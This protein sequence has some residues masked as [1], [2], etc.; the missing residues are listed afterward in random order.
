MPFLHGIALNLGFTNWFLADP[1]LKQY[2]A[3]M[4]WSMVSIR[5]FF[6]FQDISNQIFLLI[7][8]LI[9][10]SFEECIHENFRPNSLDCTDL[11][12]C[13]VRRDAEL[14]RL[15]YKHFFWV[16]PIS[17]SSFLLPRHKNIF[18]SYFQWCLYI[19]ILRNPA[20]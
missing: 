13:G 18:F 17:P 6:S 9:K 8:L 2:L 19:R 14:C 12:Q 16:K 15:C 5:H 3:K 11:N 7:K 10:V 4:A 1:S 20:S